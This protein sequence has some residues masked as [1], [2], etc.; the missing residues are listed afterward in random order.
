MA[1]AFKFPTESKGNGQKWQVR[2]IEDLVY[3]C[4]VSVLPRTTSIPRVRCVKVEAANRNKIIVSLLLDQFL[5]MVVGA[6]LFVM[7][8]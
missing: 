2:L 8:C 3:I 1:F 6:K 5:L 4:K 7:V